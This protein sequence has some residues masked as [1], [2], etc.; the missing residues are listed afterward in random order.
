GGTE[1]P[2]RGCLRPPASRCDPGLSASAVSTAKRRRF[3][4]VLDAGVANENSPVVLGRSIGRTMTMTVKD[5]I[6][7][8]SLPARRS[9]DAPDSVRVL[10]PRR[11]APADA[12]RP[13]RAE[14]NLAALRHNLRIV[15]RHAGEA[16]VWPV[17]K[18][19]GYGH[20][21]PAV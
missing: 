18:A 17:L 5:P 19:D 7:D 9:T 20:G 11:A 4:A 13:T 12:L 3:L 10:K 15:A 6:E 2:T 21:A 14:V 16:R 8:G 1:F